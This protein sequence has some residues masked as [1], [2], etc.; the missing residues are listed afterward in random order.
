M[1]SVH[2]D[3]MEYSLCIQRERGRGLR[4]DVEQRKRL[5]G[6]VDEDVL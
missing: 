3:F 6:E 1:Y 4:Q 5:T 2:C